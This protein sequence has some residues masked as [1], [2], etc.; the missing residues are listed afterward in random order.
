M[1]RFDGPGLDGHNLDFAHL[2]FFR[3]FDGH[4]HPFAYRRRVNHVFG[5]IA[6]SAILAKQHI[7]LAS[8]SHNSGNSFGVLRPFLSN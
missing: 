4:S 5:N 1:D 2:V 6:V 3:I 7:A 8:T